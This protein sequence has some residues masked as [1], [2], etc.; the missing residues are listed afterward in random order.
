MRALLAVV[1]LLLSALPVSAQ[2]L[3]GVVT[4]QVVNKTAGGASTAGT[5]V[6]LIAFGRKEQVPLG[7]RSAQSDPDGRYSFDGLD[8]DPNLVYI[9]L[10][11]YQ[12]VNYPTIQFYLRNGLEVWSINQHFYPPGLVEH[13]VAIFM[14]KKLR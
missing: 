9:A 1:L 14:G 13:E 7:Q 6:V 5:T 8:R 2:P 4:G 3:D 12:N 11:R 10:A